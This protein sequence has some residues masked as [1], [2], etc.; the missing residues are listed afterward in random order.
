MDVQAYMKERV[1]L[2]DEAIEARLAGLEPLPSALSGAMRHLLFPG[3]KRLRPIFSLATAEAVGGSAS[4]ALPIALAVATSTFLSALV[5][6]LLEPATLPRPKVDT[7]SSLSTPM[8]RSCEGPA[9]GF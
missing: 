3:G 1:P 5:M 7:H 4:A 8:T 6:I 9:R 2:V